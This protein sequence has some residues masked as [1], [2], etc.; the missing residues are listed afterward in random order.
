LN[1]ITQEFIEYIEKHNLDPANTMLWMVESKLTCNI[2][3][4]PFYMKS[5][6]EEYGKGME[7]ADVYSGKFTHIDLSVSTTY[8]AY[9]AYMLGGLIRKMACKI[10]PYESEPGETHRAIEKAVQ[11]LVPAFEG[12]GSIEE[13]LVEALSFFENIKASY[14]Q[15]PKVAIFGDFYVRDNDVMNQELIKTIECAGGEVLPTPYNDYV[16]ITV[17]NN[18]RRS[19]ERGDY[20][21]YSINRILISVLKMLEDRYYRHF[22]KYLGAPPVIQPKKLE[23]HL[24]KFN[25][26]PLHSGE[27]YD[28]ILKIFYL[29]ENF[30]DIRLFV[31]TN[32]A[33]C[34]PSLITEAMTEEIHRITGIPVITIT[35]DGTSEFKNDVI[36]PYL[37]C[38]DKSRGNSNVSM[39]DS[40]NEEARG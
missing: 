11:L 9:F 25:V 23:K 26:D 32:P 37:Q 31:Q 29:I 28:N 17:E 36:V 38:L 8:Y 1:I 13:A 7:K 33:F 15:K 6:L 3:L 24:E 2:R 12:N 35:Y 40:G 4:Y 30:P 39:I 27:S 19:K 18:L 16:K 20:L 22:K 10:R 5:L 34:C 14:G 21:E